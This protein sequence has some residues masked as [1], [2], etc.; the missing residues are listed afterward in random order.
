MR[1]ALLGAGLIG[2]ER[3]LAIEQLRSRGRDVEV[4]AVFDPHLTDVEAFQKRFKVPVVDDIDRLYDTVPDWVVI[5]APHDTAAQ[6]AIESLRHGFQVLIEK[7]LGRSSDEARRIAAAAHRPNQ[8]WA[9][10]NYRF[11]EGIAAAIDDIRN[12]RFGPL[13]SVNFT[14]GHGSSPDAAKSWKLDPIRA[15]GGCLIDPGIHLLDLC[16]LISPDQ[17]SVTA[18]WSWQGFWNTGIEE[19]CRLHMDGGGFLIDAEISIVRW[20]SVFRME[21][22]GRDGYGVVTGRNRSYGIQRYIRGRRWAWQGGVSQA[23][24]EELVVETNGD[25]VFANEMDALFFGKGN[26]ALPVGRASD[27]IAAMELLDDCR[28][29]IHPMATPGL[30]ALQAEVAVS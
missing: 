2:R 17:L 8:L 15:G 28:A 1:I 21:I 13:I 3:L 29:K 19:E 5:A 7:P 18:G 27:A 23:D 30:A 11:Y 4:C 20:R 12:Q 6:L 24:S 22:H 25:E 26:T 10:F 14:L 9:G 16:R